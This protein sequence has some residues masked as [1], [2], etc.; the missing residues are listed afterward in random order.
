M[1]NTLNIGLTHLIV[2]LFCSSIFYG[3]SKPLEEKSRDIVKEVEQ[4]EGSITEAE[5]QQFDKRIEELK[6]EFEKNKASL[7]DSA[8][9]AFN[10][11]MGRYQ[12]LRFMGELGG[13]KQDMKDALDQFEGAMELVA[14]SLQNQTIEQ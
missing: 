2:L 4:K 10:K 11:E 1:K 7:S 13:F 3:C 6:T 5:W 14:D 9:T 12:M 8:R